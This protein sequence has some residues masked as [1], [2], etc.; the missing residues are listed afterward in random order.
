[1]REQYTEMENLPFV[2]RDRR[3]I[4]DRRAKWRGGRR[5]S[6]WTHKRPVSY[7]TLTG[8]SPAPKWGPLLRVSIRRQIR[9]VFS[10]V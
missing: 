10:F 4:P 7:D 9:A 5:D 1:M 2:A 3:R 8:L 6:D